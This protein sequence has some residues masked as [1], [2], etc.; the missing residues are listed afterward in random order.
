[1]NAAV[2]LD[3]KD[4]GEV[5]DGFLEANSSPDASTWAIG[6]GGI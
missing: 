1:M 6:P 2:A 5:A 4:P 3:K